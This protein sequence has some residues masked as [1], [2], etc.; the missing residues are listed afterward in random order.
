MSLK[1]NKKK[2]KTIKLK[3]EVP[4]NFSQIGSKSDVNMTKQIQIR[5]IEIG[6]AAHTTGKEDATFVIQD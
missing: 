6:V 5:E 4:L 1:P 2:K 3:D